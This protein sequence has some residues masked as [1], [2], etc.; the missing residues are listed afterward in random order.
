LDRPYPQAI[1][2][3]LLGYHYDPATKVFDLSY[4]ALP[5]TSRVFIPHIKSLDISQVA[6]QG[7]RVDKQPIPGGDSG[8]LFI[9]TGEEH[10][11]VLHLTIE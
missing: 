3:K 11:V 10:R 4:D 5:G 9:T 2:G 6:Q 1:N 8:V 7:A